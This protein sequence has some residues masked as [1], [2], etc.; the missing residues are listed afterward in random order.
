MQIWT[1]S[2]WTVWA[3]GRSSHY[4][5]AVSALQQIFL[6]SF[7]QTC[8]CKSYPPATWM[9][10]QSNRN[11]ILHKTYNLHQC[12]NI[13]PDSL[14][15]ILHHWPI[16]HYQHFNPIFNWFW[17]PG[18]RRWGNWSLVST[19]HSKSFY[20][21]FLNSHIFHTFKI[22]MTGDCWWDLNKPV[23]NFFHAGGTLLINKIVR[24]WMNVIGGILG[25]D[26]S[27]LKSDWILNLNR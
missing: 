22:F 5:W 4:P 2:W 3:E 26:V 15:M 11:M 25:M 17:R 27:H 18:V 24:H 13:V 21:I 7:P 23:I 14:P 16:H 19:Y 12:E 1:L 8:L 9:G 10:K 20:W 6:S